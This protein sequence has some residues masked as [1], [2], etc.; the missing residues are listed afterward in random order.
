MKKILRGLPTT[1][2]KD[3]HVAVWPEL[4]LRS[5]QVE[6]ESGGLGRPLV[7][8]GVKIHL[9]SEKGPTDAKTSVT[10]FPRTLILYILKAAP[11]IMAS[12]RQRNKGIYI[13]VYI[14][15]FYKCKIY[16]YICIYTYLG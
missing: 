6:E 8:K 1:G 7:K 4:A 5:D 13:Y 14:Y 3:F 12:F 15:I 16:T 11:S 10:T 2:Q 9:Y